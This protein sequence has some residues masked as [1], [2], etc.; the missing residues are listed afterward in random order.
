MHR[1]R[2][3]FQGRRLARVPALALVWTLTL[4]FLL[5]AAPVT[6]QTVGCSTGA[7]F[8][9]T[10][11]DGFGNEILLERP[12]QRIFSA[13]LAMDS[14]LLSLV[15]PGRVVGVTR[16]AADP[17]QSAV[18]DKVAD[19]MAQIDQLNPETVLAT[20]PDIV[21]VAFY[22]N[23]DAVRQIRDL[24]L[25][26]YTFT[27]F[28]SLFDVIDNIE[29]MADITGCEAAAADIIDGVYADYGRLAAKIAS[30]A[31]PSVLSWDTWGSTAGSGTTIHDI[32]QMAGGVNAAAEHGIVGWQEIDVEA[33][34]AMNPDVIIT[35]Y[36]DDFARS[37]L[38]DPAFQSVAAIRAGRVF[39]ISHTEALDQTVFLA[40]REL[41]QK[42]HPEVFQ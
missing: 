33:I 22:S 16:F 24:G 13:G 14:I 21:L 35:A 25:K 37:V 8:P 40:V 31:R 5:A 34:I 28:S 20:Q 11:V 39:H 18:A 17:S 38:N 27:G 2:R 6:A 15:D 41:A 32:I 1:M 36:G 19:H 7:G 10:V 12:P 4:S 23:Q 42:L 30:A 29:R 3:L 26:V 9:R